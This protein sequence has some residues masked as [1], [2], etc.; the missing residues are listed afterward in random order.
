V[1]TLTETLPLSAAAEAT[2]KGL[3]ASAA[4][5]VPT[6]IGGV[7]TTAWITLAAAKSRFAPTFGVHAAPA[8]EEEEENSPQAAPPEVHDIFSPFR[9]SSPNRR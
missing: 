1:L 3:G 7:V 8:L 4:G 5:Y 2:E 9:V 6:T